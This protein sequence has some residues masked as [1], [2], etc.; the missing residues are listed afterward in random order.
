MDRLPKFALPVDKENP[1]GYF[2]RK[3]NN[4]EFVNA[5]PGYARVRESSNPATQLR[6]TDIIL[7]QYNARRSTI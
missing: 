5:L 7:H 6:S 3:G 4:A 2:M 1:T